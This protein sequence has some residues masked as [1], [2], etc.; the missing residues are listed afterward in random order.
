MKDCLFLVR[1]VRLE[2]DLRYRV[3]HLWIA[4]VGCPTQN[5]LFVWEEGDSH[6]YVPLNKLIPH[7]QELTDI[8]IPDGDDI[9][10]FHAVQLRLEK[11][12]FAL[13]ATQQALWNCIQEHNSLI[14]RSNL[15]PGTSV[16][17]LSAEDRN[18]LAVP[19]DN[20]LD[21]AI[22]TQNAL[23]EF[24]KQWKRVSTGKAFDNTSDSL[25]RLAEQVRKEPDILDPNLC[26]FLHGYWD[27][28]GLRLRK[29][30]DL[31]QHKAVIASD[32]RLFRTKS[33][34]LGIYM[35]LPNNPEW[36]DSANLEYGNPRIHAV[37]YVKKEFNE[38]VRICYLITFHLY[39]TLPKRVTPDGTKT[40][41]LFIVPMREPARFP[42]GLDGHQK[43]KETET[44]AAI[45][46]TLV[47]TNKWLSKVA[48]AMP[49]DPDVSE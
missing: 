5:M 16:L 10:N 19:V 25:R 46:E 43:I 2:R 37:A 13:Q 49:D 38:L 47:A 34:E 40:Q 33:G 6:L 24:I 12:P 9:K 14:E 21:A 48:Q 23:T 17:H 31:A 32:A 27:N 26:F 4:G 35:L 29:Y 3:N 20:F 15:S 42:S 45:E 7:L 11:L 36:K 28:H 22:R 39:Q 1:C 8:L 18:R 44:A 41:R 30:R